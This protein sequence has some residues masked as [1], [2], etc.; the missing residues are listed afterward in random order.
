[1]DSEDEIPATPTI[2]EPAPHRK[3]KVRRE[4]TKQY[5]DEDGYMVT[6][7]EMELQSEDD[8]ESGESKEDIKPV[9]SK[10]KAPSP[11]KMKPPPKTTNKPPL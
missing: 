3:R 6:K 11:K 10:P 4:V 8:E 9:I 2:A 1:E 7:T 5:K